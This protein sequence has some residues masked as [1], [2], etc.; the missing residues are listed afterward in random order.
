MQ[1]QKIVDFVAA[2]ANGNGALLKFLIKRY[3]LFAGPA[4]I[5]Q[6]PRRSTSR[7]HGFATEMLFSNVP[8]ACRPIRECGCGWVPA[9]K[10]W[11]RRR[12]VAPTQGLGWRF[13]APSAPSKALHWDH[14]VYGLKSSE[15]D[16]DRDS[17]DQL[18]ESLY[19]C[20]SP[21]AAAGR[22][23]ST[24]QTTWPKG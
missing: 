16:A 6:M 8:M 22:R 7:S 9:E 1:K 18:G 15:A 2:A 19:H 20:C 23:F 21:P 17:I 14:A 11:Q 4:R 12:R 10:Q 3:G 13:P 24:Q 5:A